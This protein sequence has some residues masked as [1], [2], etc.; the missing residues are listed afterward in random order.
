MNPVP[1]RGGIN[2]GQSDQTQMK[3]KDKKDEKCCQMIAQIY[4]VLAVDEM[5]D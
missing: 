4:D 3:R 2:G 1:T 5:I